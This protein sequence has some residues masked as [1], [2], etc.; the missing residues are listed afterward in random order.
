MSKRYYGSI[1]L[2][3]MIEAA[4]KGHSAFSKSSKNGK[5]YCNVNLWDNEKVDEYG[6]T[7][8]L[9]VNPSKEMKDKEDRF[10][11]GNFK[12]AEDSKPISSKDAAGLD[13]DLPS[14]PAKNITEPIDDLPF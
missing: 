11:I 9:Q 10:Y 8:S 4:K 13:V 2:T 1:C 5:I 12:K 14:Q 6:N 7:M 3:D